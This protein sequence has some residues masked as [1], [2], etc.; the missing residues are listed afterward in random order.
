MI[1]KKCK[2]QIPDESKVCPKCEADLANVVEAI[3]PAGTGKKLVITNPKK[4]LL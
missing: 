2:E 1:C 4:L 3:Q